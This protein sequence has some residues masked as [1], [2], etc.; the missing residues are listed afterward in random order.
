M[1]LGT[2]TLRARDRFVAERKDWGSWIR[3]DG[4]QNSHNYLA[5]S[6]ESYVEYWKRLCVGLGRCRG[7]VLR[8]DCKLRQLLVSSV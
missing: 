7:F 1:I 6:N 5:G 2:W 4:L 8:M 3:V